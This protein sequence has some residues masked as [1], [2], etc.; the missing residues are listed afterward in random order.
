M[1]S[2]TER[3]IIDKLGASLPAGTNELRFHCVQCRRRKGSEDRSGHL[4]VNVIEGKFICFRCGWKGYVSYL[5]QTLGITAHAQVADW[6]DTISKMSLFTGVK[7]DDTYDNTLEIEYPCDVV[8]PLSSPRAWNY[9]TTPKSQGGRGLTQQHIDY[10]KI[11]VGSE[12]NWATRVFIP[13]LH[14]GNVVF[15]VARTFAGQ[16]PKYMNPKDVSK[17]HYW[18]GLDQAKQFDWVIVTEGVFSA[19]AAGP[20]AIAAFGKSVSREQREILV[21]CGF[22]S[23]YVAL[24]GDAKAEA[25]ELCAWL[26][27]RNQ[28]VHLVN[29]VVGEDPDSVQ[30]FPARLESATQY[31]Y[32]SMARSLLL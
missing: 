29:M 9:L 32:V 13:T 22:K 21:N 31:D 26:H 2:A 15:W 19:I 16:E 5:M 12:G 18:F 24:D 8:H 10:Y 6:G 27:S 1:T 14:E 7:V 30:D 17:K 3:A 23:I 4:Y 25:V 20:N 11:V 28:N